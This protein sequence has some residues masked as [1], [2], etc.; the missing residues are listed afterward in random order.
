MTSIKNKINFNKIR[1]KGSK[2]KAKLKTDKEEKKVKKN[3]KVKKDKKIKNSKIGYYI[4]IAIT[5]LAIIFLLAIIAFGLYIIVKAPAFDPDKLYEKEASII[6]FS[7]GEIMATLGTSV[8]DD[9][10][11]KREK[12]T[13][14]ELSQVFI[15]ALIATED[16]RFFQ[17]NGFDLFRFLK[18]SFGQLMGNSDAGGASTL[19][20]QVEKNTWIDSTCTGSEGSIRN[21]SDTYMA[22]FKV[23]KNYTKNEIIEFYVNDNCL[24][25]RIYGV[26]EAAEYYFGKSVG[27]LSLPEAAM[28][29]GLFQAPTAY[30]PYVYP[31]N[32]N[33]RKNVV[34]N[35]MLR[36]GYITKEECETAKSID[37][38]DLLVNSNTSSVSEYQGAVDTIV[39]EIINK[40]GVSPY[41]VSMEIY[42]T[43]DKSKQDVINKF[44]NEELGYEFKDEKIQV[45]ISM[46]NNNTGAMIAVGAGR[47]KD[48]ELGFNYAT[49]ID[50]HPGSTAKPIFEYGPGIEYLKWSTYTP[51]FDEDDI[52]YSSG[53]VIS[54]WNNQYDGLV[55]LKYALS[56]SKNTVALQ[57]FQTIDNDLKYNFAT[58]LGITPETT[59]GYLHEAHAV[60]GFNGVT[61]TELAGAYSAFANGGYFT[62]P[63]TVNKIVYRDTGEVVEP[64]HKREKVM[65]PQ[66]AYMITTILFNVTP[67]S[68]RV[69]GTQIATK[70]GTSSYDDKALKEYGVPSST[71]RDSW[72]ATYSPDYTLSFWYG[73][74][75]LYSD[76]YNT[77]SSSTNNRNK[78]QG[79]LLNNLFEKNSKFTN[80][81]GISSVKVE[82]ETIPAQLAS[83]YTPDNL[84]ETHLFIKG[85]EPSEVSPR[86]AKLSDPTD[87]NVIETN[88]GATLSWTSPGVPEVSTEEYLKNY[89]NT[90][91]GKYS[92][93][94]YNL[95]I[96]YNSTYMG[97][98]GFDIYL[99]NGDTLKYVGFT[100]DTT[101]SISNTTGYNEVVVK[102]AYSKFKANASNGM[103][104]S[105]TGSATKVDIELLALEESGKIHPTISIGST[106][107]DAGINTI[108]IIVN[109][110]DVTDTID[111]STITMTIKNRVTNETLNS[112]SDIDTSQKGWYQ[113]TYHVIYL[114]VTYNSEGRSIYIE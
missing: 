18:A 73:Y 63:Y 82:L 50:S 23:E 27:N 69:S 89:F 55:T 12:V 26:K 94:Y 93:K 72:V 107:P 105:I 48:R 13:Y 86:F 88:N 39:K 74:D 4:L 98:F 84:V 49:E 101:Y 76:Y 66:T 1:N 87:L 59:D 30:D 109:G 25:G 33:A 43:I 42:S 57:A 54:N 114:G 31:D 100:T 110:L 2:I 9:T 19:T 53:Q 83:E 36:H 60:G 35:L 75:E 16:S 77:M 10:V 95:R 103:T 99:K 3:K 64:K 41:D 5:S 113:I 47:N 14:D 17:H 40:Y 7:N 15:D 22:K 97:D 21:I 32:A 80:P 45:G 67:S 44:Y 92:E 111:K 65:S 24:G 108:K 96:Q 37:I 62:E 20:M 29:A 104:K 81:G 6:Y 68:V 102:S 52:A 112:L 78:I 46:I 71:I 11:E 70:T 90:N 8:G 106:V 58:S 61:P 91:Y 79:V 85:T 51:F 34:L 56:K 28:I 38:Q